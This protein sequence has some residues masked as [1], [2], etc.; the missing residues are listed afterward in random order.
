M[1]ELQ[2]LTMDTNSWI[3]TGIKANPYSVIYA[4]LS[5]Q[6]VAASI[7]WATFW[8]ANSSDDADDTYQLRQAGM[9]QQWKPQVGSLWRYGA[10]GTFV[11]GDDYEITFDVPNNLVTINNDTYTGSDCSWG[12]KY[13]G[14]YSIYVGANN[15]ANS[16]YRASGARWYAFSISENNNKLIDLIPVIDENN[17]VCFYDKVSGNYFYNAGSGTFTAGPLISSINATPSKNILAATG[18]TI[19]ISVSC[20]NAWTVTG[21]T[22]LTLSSTGDTG[23]TTIT[24][25]APSYIGATAR[26]DV[27]TFT[28]SVT[29][30]EIEISIK[31]KKYTNGQPM[32]LGSAEISEIYL[33][34]DTITEAYLGDVLVFSAVAPTPTGGTR[35]ISISSIPIP[36]LDGEGNAGGTDISIEDENQN[37]ATLSLTFSDPWDSSSYEENVDATQGFTASYASGYFEVEG[38]WGDDITITY[39]YTDGICTS[40]PSG[41]ET[42]QP[43]FENGVISVNFPTPESDAEC[44]CTNAGGTWDGVECTY[45]EPDPC[46]GMGEEEC[47]CVSNGGSWIVPEIGDPYCEQ[48]STDCEGDPE[49][50]C[51]QGGGTWTYD[52]AMADYYCDC[53][54]DPECECIS[55]GGTWDG[56]DCTYP[57]PDPE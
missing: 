10:V 2:Y 53:G 45:P 24:A 22:W 15:K 3:N 11:Y 39:S 26:T 29:G 37:Y 56:S 21:N 18:E 8:G 4:K 49:C 47:E 17:V 12:T 46:E 25:T 40:V 48:Q 44:E 33:G 7:D 43:T 19:N 55:A 16:G 1:R 28:D 38:E 51:T 5:P 36:T 35:V 30:D 27:L 41:Y 57:E 32:Y 34:A 9:A 20:E 42:E 23:S 6:S 54:G 52:E 50:L 14:T 31:Q 13:Y